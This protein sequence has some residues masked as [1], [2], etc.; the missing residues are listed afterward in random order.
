DAL[1]ADEKKYFRIIDRA[2]MDEVGANP[3]AAFALSAENGGAFSN[4]MKGEAVKPG[5]GGTHG[6]YPDFQ[7]IKTGY[8]ICGPGI[9]KGAVIKGMNQWDQAAVICKLL[10]LSMPTMDGK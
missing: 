4:S 8:V 7:N 9:K 10:G 5:H 2:K 3:L 6:H 1:P